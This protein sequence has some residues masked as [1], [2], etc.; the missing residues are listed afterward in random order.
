MSLDEA[1]QKNLTWVD[2]SGRFG[3]KADH[4]SQVPRNSGRG[5]DSIRIQSHDRYFDSL[6]VLDL[7]HMPVGCGT[8]PAF[9]T[10][11]T[12]DWPKGGEIDIIEG[13]NDQGNNQYTLH[14]T[15]GCQ[16]PKKDNNDLSGNK[17]AYTGEA[18]VLDCSPTAGCSIDGAA[19]H[20]FGPGMNAAGGGFLVTRIKQDSGISM[21][22]YPRN[23]GIPAALTDGR[24]S[25][26]EKDLG[27]RIAHFPASESCD[28]D[29]S[30]TEQQLIFNTAMCGGWCA[31]RYPGAGQCQQKYPGKGWQDIIY[32]HPE[33][34]NDAYWLINSLKVFQFCEECGSGPGAVPQSSSQAPPSSTASPS[35]SV[36]ISAAPSPSTKTSVAPSPSSSAS[37]SPSPQ[38][39]SVAP[40]P[41]P[42]PSSTTEAPPTTS[43]ETQ[44]STTSEETPT[45]TETATDLPIP[46]KQHGWTS[47]WTSTYTLPPQETGWTSQWTSAWT[48]TYTLPPQET[49]W[50][51]EWAWTST[52]SLPAQ[53][54][55]W[56]SWW[57]SVLSFKPGGE[58]SGPLSELF[59]TS[60]KSHNSQKGTTAAQ[61]SADACEPERPER[62]ERPVNIVDNIVDEF[63]EAYERWMDEY[64]WHYHSQWNGRWKK[65][66]K[67]HAGDA[68]EGGDDGDA[69]NSN[70]DGDANDAGD[71]PASDG[72][73]TKTVR[74][75]RQHARRWHSGSS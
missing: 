12:G 3:M 43:S 54:T 37:P 6:L 71:G 17:E 58:A 39:S 62:P 56:T 7:A 42:P 29:K 4:W 16:I 19:G 5:R 61:A 44:P 60:H 1:R 45:T 69:G 34:F 27:Q 38:T 47:A 49:G 33:E 64:Q 75:S 9:W 50:T 68:A 21:W 52:Y 41:P 51:S 28:L 25:I 46:S 67:K 24:T 30:L 65:G 2:S 14:T 57:E 36:H 22:W 63:N 20:T 35:S 31:S 53:Q 72:Q 32:D 70:D 18:R 11:G 8:W 13:T 74:R 55:G 48:S 23:A 66:D 26:D 15:T 73:A 10:I 40:P 59:G